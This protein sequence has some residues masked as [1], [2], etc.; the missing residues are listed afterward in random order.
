MRG[1]LFGRLLRMN[2]CGS[3][4][5]Y[6]REP[7]RYREAEFTCTT[8]SRHEGTP[9]RLRHP[10][11]DHTGHLMHMSRNSPSSFSD[12][13]FF[14]NKNVLLHRAYVRRGGK[15]TEMDWLDFGGDLKWPAPFDASSGRQLMEN[16]GRRHSR[17]ARIHLLGHTPLPEH[18]AHSNTN[19]TSKWPW[20]A[21]RNVSQ[22][23][24]AA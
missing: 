1:R 20:K 16:A 15:L 2:R 13:R 24:H 11:V 6:Q 10:A 4:R 3:I 7:Y 17:A 5:A 21:G 8:P 23:F 14:R 22:R 9:L 18:G 19:A 12:M